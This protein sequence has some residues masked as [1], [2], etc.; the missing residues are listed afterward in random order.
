MK[1]KY[2]GQCG[3]CMN[4]IEPGQEIESRVLVNPVTG[5][6]GELEWIHVSCGKA[7]EGPL[8]D[9]GSAA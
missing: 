8:P 6:E 9:L 7:E 3:S 5:E 4:W 2:Q 1:A